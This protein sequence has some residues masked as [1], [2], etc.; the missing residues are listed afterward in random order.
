MDEKVAGLVV[1]LLSL[2]VAKRREV[3]WPKEVG[4]E[5][6]LSKYRLIV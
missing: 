4:V 3:L 6:V 2:D 1:D 5:K